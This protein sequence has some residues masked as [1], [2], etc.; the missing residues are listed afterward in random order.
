[1]GLYTNVLMPGKGKIMML[2]VVRFVIYSLLMTL[3]V[4]A[5]IANFTKGNTIPE[6]ET[7]QVVQVVSYEDQDSHMHNDVYVEKA[8][9]NVYR[10]DQDGFDKGDTVRILVNADGSYNKLQH[11]AR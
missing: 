10:F 1:M 7:A 11:V 2:K 8:D 6:I 4:I 9:G 3:T 5:L